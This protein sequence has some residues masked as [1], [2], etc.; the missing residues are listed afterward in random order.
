[1]TMINVSIENQGRFSIFNSLLCREL[2]RWSQRLYL[3]IP[4]VLIPID[5]LKS[6]GPPVLTSI[7]TSNQG[8][9]TSGLLLLKRH[10]YEPIP[11]SLFSV[12]PSGLRQ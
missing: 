9:G 7:K 10:F 12:I 8:R 11:I 1:M 5:R 3:Q 2:L 4:I 6:W